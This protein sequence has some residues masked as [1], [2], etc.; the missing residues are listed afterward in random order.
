MEMTI[1]EPNDDE[2][3][4]DDDNFHSLVGRPTLFDEE[5]ANRVIEAV[6]RG[7]TFS[8]AAA[9]GGISYSTL[10]RWR[11]KGQNC[12]D[13]EDDFRQF[14]KL[15]EQA[16]GEA[17]LRLVNCIHSAAESGDWKAASWIMERRYSGDWGKNGCGLDPLEPLFP[18]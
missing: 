17:A 2:P 13:E 4:F 16:K 14:W 9:Y 5:T 8:L 15:L 7:L 10:N 6:E 11:K 3:P 18:F 12:E 1:Q